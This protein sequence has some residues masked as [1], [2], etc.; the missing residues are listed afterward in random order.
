[1]EIVHLAFTDFTA[2]GIHFLLSSRQHSKW[3][4]EHQFR[5]S[6]TP[7]CWLISFPYPPTGE[8]WFLEFHWSTSWQSERQQLHWGMLRKNTD[9][10][11]VQVSMKK[12]QQ[13]RTCSSIDCTV[14]AFAA[15]SEMGAKWPVAAV[16]HD[17]PGIASKAAFDAR[18][19][20]RCVRSSRDAEDFTRLRQSKGDVVRPGLTISETFSFPFHFPFDLALKTHFFAFPPRATIL[21]GRARCTIVTMMGPPSEASENRIMPMLWTWD[22]VFQL[23]HKVA[24]KVACLDSSVVKHLLRSLEVP[25]V[26]PGWGTVKSQIFVQ[27]LFSY[28][29]TFEK[30]TKFNTVW[31]FLFVLRPSN[32]NVIFAFR[33]S[34]IS[35]Y[36]PVSSKTYENG[37]RKKICNFTVFAIFFVSAKIYLRIA[38]FFSLSLSVEERK[39]GFQHRP[40]DLSFWSFLTFLHHSV[41]KVERHLLWNFHK[42]IQ[43][44]S[45]SN[46]PPK[47]LACTRF[48]YKVVHKIGRLQKLNRTREIELNFFTA[49]TIIPC[50]RFLIFA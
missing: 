39:T 31:K 26:N 2:L 43:R 3:L 4:V 38:F 12:K 48:L 29:R 17:S 40:L 7:F 27:Y 33:L 15:L 46:V 20:H 11:K 24:G 32:F 23:S 13:H 22:R 18:S 25:G 42:K 16:F 1:M 19:R 36:E 37:Y 41:D 28:F 10:N 50:L 35:W 5:L 21:S 44:K 49:W 14:V 47:L 45:W 9:R 6:S 8:D 34:K 30:S